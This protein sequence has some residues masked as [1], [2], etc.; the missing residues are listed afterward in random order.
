MSLWNFDVLAEKAIGSLSDYFTYREGVQ[1]A[2][3]LQPLMV[4]TWQK[5]LIPVLVIVL[6]FFLLRKSL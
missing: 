4:E 2:K 5:T 3:E 6:A 1:S